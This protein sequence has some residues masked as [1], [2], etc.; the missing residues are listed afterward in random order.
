LQNSALSLAQD[1]LTMGAQARI[2]YNVHHNEDKFMWK[3]IAAA[4]LL[5][6]AGPLCR[7]AELNIPAGQTYT[8][9][10]VQSD[11]RLD[12]L[13]IGD[14]AQIRFEEGVSRWRVDAKRVSVGNN[15]VIDGRGAAGGNGANGVAY[16][17]AAKDCTDGAAGGTGAAGGAGGNGVAL[18]LWWG[19][20]QIGSMKIMVDGGA[21]GN[22]GQG[23][24][25]Q[26][27]GKVNRCN[28]PDGG[29][30]GPGGS[31]GNGGKGGAIALSYFDAAGK[32]L[33]G[34]HDRLGIST[35]G[36]RPGA[37]SAGGPGGNPAEGRF[38]RTPVGD[39][40]FP[41]GD[42]GAP[43]AAGAAGAPG[44]AGAVDIQTVAA[45]SNP[46]WMSEAT[47]NAPADRGTVISL[48]QKVEALQAARPV[49]AAGGVEQ[50]LQS[51]Q[52][53]VRKLEERI[54]ALEAR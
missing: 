37:G 13:T 49:P 30:G 42:A 7:A 46:S 36:G 48:Q 25:G 12:R 2:K 29:A 43:G 15:V 35:A 32:G 17:D 3:P 5:L 52:D 14:N 21:G 20:E 24:R 10:A 16:K 50:Q 34:L 27:A 11:L 38:Q 53:Q 18:V 51:L 40:W 4:A 26:D 41:N 9:S 45:S 31:G 54:K 19:V 6:A 28:G 22:G 44:A 33:A 1:L 47:S 8:V 23:G 39:R